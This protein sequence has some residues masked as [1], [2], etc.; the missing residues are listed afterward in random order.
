MQLLSS[1]LK[2]FL[3]EQRDLHQLRRRLLGGQIPSISRSNGNTPLL[4]PTSTY[5]YL[6]STPAPKRTSDPKPG[7]TCLHF[8]ENYQGVDLPEDITLSRCIVDVLR[9]TYGSAR[10]LSVKLG[11]PTAHGAKSRYLHTLLTE[12]Q[13]YP[14]QHY[15]AI[16]RRLLT[17]YL[18]ITLHAWRL[19]DMMLYN[20]CV[21]NG[22][23]RYQLLY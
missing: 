1:E 3:P 13:S 15:P 6:W 14:L 10:T 4:L 19:R 7:S 5:P 17:R 20:V 18:E 12:L 21:P 23:C 9:D 16:I 11:F 22:T 8:L 2:I